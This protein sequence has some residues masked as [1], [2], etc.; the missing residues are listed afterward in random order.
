[1]H[2]HH[3]A[4][5]LTKD[6]FILK[7]SF[8]VVSTA[9]LGNFF[10][11]LF[12]VILGRYFS[13]EDY[14]ILNSLLAFL[15]MS[16]LFVHIFFGQS[17]K[18]VAEIKDE[19]YPN[20]ISSLFF[21]LS[22]I[23]AVTS[24]LAF[25]IINL[26]S[27]Q[28]ASYLQL[29][30]TNSRSIIFYFSLAVAGFLFFI[31]I[32][33]FLQGLMRFKAYSLIQF[34]TTSVKFVIALIIVYL[35]LA[36]KDVFLL[37]GISALLI[38]I[39]GILLLKKNLNFEKI[40]D[41]DTKNIMI[42]IKYS[43]GGALA[44]VGI[45]IML[46]IDII[47][48]KHYFSPETAGI[49]SLT[50]V[51]GKIIFYAASPVAVVMLPV[52]A[53]KYKKKENF[54]QPFVATLFLTLLIS[55]GI[56][57]VF[58]FFPEFITKLLFGSNEKKLLSANYLPIFSIYMILYTLLA[59][60]SQFFIAISKFKIASIAFL[61]AVIQFV[62]ILVFHNSLYAIIWDSIVASG[63]VVLIMILSLISLNKSKS[64]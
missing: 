58:I 10:A 16:H 9:L 37:S 33:H 61:A 53:S 23:F 4:K 38:S 34:L 41:F 26:F 29:T 24:V 43:L 59:F 2:I 11:Y 42:L 64:K 19:D 47:Q 52:V 31:Y 35:A 1:M 50:S 15:A 18:L 46:N 63:T 57:L 27:N 40:R 32:M 60:L 13:V 20:K 62:L 55:M 6:K 12:Q 5:A 8:F 48:V 56:A 21:T 45:T 30:D 44:F 3:H 28:I 17:P 39:L 7:S 49:Y 22:K 14:G 36:V 54:K 25:L 51:I